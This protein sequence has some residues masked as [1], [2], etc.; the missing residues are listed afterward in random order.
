[1]LRSQTKSKKKPA[2]HTEFESMKAIVFGGSG[3]LGSHV[4]D[5]LTEAGHEVTV[6]DLRP[7]SYLQSGQL[8]YIGDILN[9][10]QV[11]SRSNY[12]SRKTI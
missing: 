7:S 9:Y 4:A 2:N 1:M 3:F 6:F 11:I 5:V 8:M 12:Q 10:E